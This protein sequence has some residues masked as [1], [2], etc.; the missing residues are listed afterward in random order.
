MC[1]RANKFVWVKAWDEGKTYRELNSLSHKNIVNVGW[2]LCFGVEETFVEF[3]SK[4]TIFWPD[5]SLTVNG[6]YETNKS[7]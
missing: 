4:K 2:I 1:V 3:P 7:Y 6:Y 5:G